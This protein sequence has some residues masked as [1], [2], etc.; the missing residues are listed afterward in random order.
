MLISVS[1]FLMI[2][3]GSQFNKCISII[4]GQNKYECLSSLAL[5][6]NN[7]SVCSYINGSYRSLCY[8]NVAEKYA[9]VSVCGKLSSSDK[10]SCIMNVSYTNKDYHDCSMLDSNNESICMQRIAL[11]TYNPNICNAISNKSA[12][13]ECL[14]SLDLVNALEKGNASYCSS[15]PNNSNFSTTSTI[16]SALSSHNLSSGLN[17][18]LGYLFSTENATMT[19]RDFCYYYVG[20]SYSNQSDCLQ[21]SNQSIQESCSSQV[22]PINN[23]IYANAT[24][25]NYTQMIDSC[26]SEGLGSTCSSI[27]LAHALVDM[28]LTRCSQLPI[29]TSETCY[30]S[31]AERLNNVSDCSYIK[32]A[33]L[34]DLC[35]M[36][37]NYNASS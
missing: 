4:L 29:N 26:I 10:V 14:N 5:T 23:S 6:T 7:A 15:L 24:G 25:V 34:N 36:S 31:I 11:N 16:S 35:V 13:A 20:V 22:I 2:P 21:I 17:I 27:A 33:S 8:L 19:P 32:N 37:V 18:Y 1:A 3:G 12:G 28:N 9:N 30:M